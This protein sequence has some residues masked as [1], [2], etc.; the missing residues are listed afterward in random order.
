MNHSNEFR[1]PHE[2]RGKFTTEDP[3]NR[4]PRLKLQSLILVEV[5][6]ADGP[7]YIPRLWSEMFHRQKTINVG[8]L[9]FDREIMALEDQ[10]LLE[11][12]GPNETAIAGKGEIHLY[13]I[14]LL[15]MMPKESLWKLEANGIQLASTTGILDVAPQG[16]AGVSAKMVGHPSQSAML[17]TADSKFDV[18]DVSPVPASAG[19]EVCSVLSSPLTFPADDRFADNICRALDTGVCKQ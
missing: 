14:L 12:S 2:E 3:L 8:C 10:G 18:A 7:C 5:F 11:Q 17:D 13:G 15:G 16:V 9:L 6:L 1:P 4:E 19:G